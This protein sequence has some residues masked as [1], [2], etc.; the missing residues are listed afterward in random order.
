MAEEFQEGEYKHKMLKAGDAIPR[1]WLMWF[2][3]DKRHT[4][5]WR[6]EAREAFRFAASKQWDE[7]DRRKLMAEMRPCL[8]FDR[9]SV[10][11]DAI[12]G[13]EI[14]NR[15]QVNF[16]PR[17]QGDAMPNELLTE[18]GRW[19]DEQADA[20]DEDSE[21]F[22]DSL[23]CGMG[24]TET[25][26]DTYDEPEGC[27]VVERID[28][29]EMY[30]DAS[31]TKA[32]LDD[33]RRAWRLKSFTAEEAKE[34]WPDAAIDDLR[35]SVWI[36]RLGMGD[37]DPNVNDPLSRY[38]EFDDKEVDE[39]GGYSEQ[40]TKG[41]MGR[42]TIAQ[43]QYYVLE[44]YVMVA[45]PFMG[46]TREMAPADFKML[47][48]N[49]QKLGMPPIESVELRRKV[50]YVAF[51]GRKVIE[52]Y[53]S[54]CPDHCTWNFI[55]GKRDR[56]KGVFYGLYRQLKDPQ[57]WANKWLSQI[58]H[59]MNSNAKGGL[60]YEQ[61]A[62]VDQ[63]DAQSNWAKPNAMIELKPGALSGP[64]P[65][66]K[67]RTPP[68][69]PSTLNFLTEFALTAI[70]DVNQ[71]G[72]LEY[73]RRQAGLTILAPLFNSLR[74]YR[75]NRGK[76]MLHYIQNYLSDGRLIRITGQQGQQYVPLMKQADA[77]YDIVVD[78]APYSPNQKEIV[79][80]SITNVMP[81]IKDVIPPEVMLQLLDYSPFPPSVV[82]KIKEV[83]QADTPEKQQA[84]QMQAR[85]ALAE[86]ALNEGKAKQAEA[87]AQKQLAEAATAGMEQG[88]NM[89]IDMPTQAEEELTMAE[90]DMARASAAEKV[91]GAR[92]KLAQAKKTEAEIGAVAAGIDATRAGIGKTM[93]DAGAVRA[94]IGKTLVDTQHVR[95]Q[96]AHVGA[97]TAA[98][99]AELAIKKT[100]A[101]KKPA[102]AKPKAGRKS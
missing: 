99:P 101:N 10:I 22:V 27:P 98:V 56:T 37:V 1:R 6:K 73:Q 66:I 94:S 33:K 47:E 13:Q 36:D 90:V 57:Q 12:A 102:G 46:T 50:W 58:L 87:T 100:A 51:L 3:A 24:C 93:A 18:A 17:E 72:V 85:A 65:K 67:E 75:R 54:P 88:G 48:K 29:I 61:G 91:A 42:F 35:G 31:T 59:I 34:R 70:R 78:D 53:K 21:A 7:E 19:F 16:L 8:T 25:R 84:K 39:A 69:M 89:T 79:W 76:V 30:W 9:S 2:D 38:D 14:Q 62:F 95:A 32:G 41:I 92:L 97:Q 82:Q 11:I 80:Q 60:M 83:V 68:P 44:P 81:A 74:R 23:W 86:I 71:A 28:P 77:K 52:H 5:P 49:M 64:A 45:D 40:D 63:S 43:M 15:Q 55:T 4:A 26:L 20:P 96:T